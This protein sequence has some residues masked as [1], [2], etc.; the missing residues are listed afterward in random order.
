MAKLDKLYIISESTKNLQISNIYFIEYKNQ[1]FPN[2]LHIH[3]I[4]SDSASSYHC[5]SRITGSNIPKWDCIFNCCSYFPIMNDPY[6]ESSEQLDD[7]FPDSIH[8]IKFHIFQNISKYLL[9]GLIPFKYKSTCEFCDNIQEKDIREN[10]MVKKCFVL[11]KEIISVFHEKNT[12][13]Q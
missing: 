8:K 9:H 13:S 10:I 5:P 7:L 1:I 3:L 11:H 4:A 12:L 2:N 6:L